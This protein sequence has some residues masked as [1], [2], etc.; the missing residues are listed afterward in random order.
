M[1]RF[2]S[3]SDA[4]LGKAVQNRDAILDE[5]FRTLVEGGEILPDT[6]LGPG[7]G[8]QKPSLRM[9]VQQ[10][11]SLYIEKHQALIRHVACD[12]FKYCETK[13]RYSARLELVRSLADA[14]CMFLSHLPI[15][16]FHLCAYLVEFEVLDKLCGCSEN[17]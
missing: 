17:K 12:R 11:V 16:L 3:M 2:V 9:R 4:D 7:E 14:L 1:Q 10:K 8:D 6:L 5:I 15:P 13:K